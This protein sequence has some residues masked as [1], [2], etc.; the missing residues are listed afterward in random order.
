M[1]VLLDTGVLGHLCHSHA[2]KAAA[3]KRKLLDLFATDA[4]LVVCIPEIADYELRRKLIHL[5]FTASLLRLDALASTYRYLPITSAVMRRAAELWA[6]SRKEGKPT[7][8]D[9]EL[10]C[11]VILAAQAE[12]QS[13]TVIT[14]NRKHLQRFVPVLDWSQPIAS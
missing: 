6:N 7:A 5:D 2:Q 12:G 11:D 9:K 3:S 4:S 13:G 8:D 10:D 1:I 14:T